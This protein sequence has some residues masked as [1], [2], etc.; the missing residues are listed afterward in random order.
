MLDELFPGPLAGRMSKLFEVPSPPTPA[1]LKRY[2]LSAEEWQGILKAQGGVC[3]I[4]GLVP[5]NKTTGAIRFVVDHEHVRGWKKLP[6]EERKM[7][8]RG[9]VCF[10]CNFTYLGRGITLAKARNVVKYLERY[11]EA[12]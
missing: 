10:W 5:R 11:A 12:W 4:C 3:G 2:G 6:P 7:W 8:V 1:T 9:L